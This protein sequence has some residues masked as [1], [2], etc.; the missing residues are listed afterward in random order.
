MSFAVLAGSGTIVS[1]ETDNTSSE[2]ES[3][4]TVS[5]SRA[6]ELNIYTENDFEKSMNLEAWMLYPDQLIWGAASME[7][8]ES[9]ENWM[10]DIE[11]SGWITESSIEQE[12]L[13]E[14]W[15]SDPTEWVV[16]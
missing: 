14:S 2:R 13:L 9:L 6:G 10:T 1:N 4:I 5:S 8:T 11:S 15:M 3:R 7:K 16:D 12:V